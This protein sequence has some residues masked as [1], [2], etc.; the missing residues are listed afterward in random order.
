MTHISGIVHMMGCT[1]LVS[2]RKRGSHWH[3]E[4]GGLQ[5]S[6]SLVFM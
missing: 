6:K 2:V 3:R 1:T 5:C 4:H